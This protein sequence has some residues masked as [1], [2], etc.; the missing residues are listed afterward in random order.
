MTVSSCF[1]SPLHLGSEWVTT[2]LRPQPLGMFFFDAS[3]SNVVSTLAYLQALVLFLKH[4]DLRAELLDVA[5]VVLLLGLCRMKEGRK[6]TDL[7]LEMLVLELKL[8]EL[9]VFIFVHALEQFYLRF[10][11]LR[12]A[13]TFFGIK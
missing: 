7:A 9:C 3:P 13:P 1:P 12:R 4:F 6:L 10:E 11:L 2:S 5:I 8:F